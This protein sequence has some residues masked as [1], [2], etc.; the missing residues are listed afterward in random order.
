MPAS[1]PHFGPR[2]DK[3]YHRDLQRRVDIASANVN[4]GTMV[5]RCKL[6]FNCSRKSMKTAC[7]SCVFNKGNSTVPTAQRVNQYKAIMDIGR[8]LSIDG[9]IREVTDQPLFL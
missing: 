8:P 9:R 2:D 6:A 5:V 1:M 4:A 3:Y 7:W